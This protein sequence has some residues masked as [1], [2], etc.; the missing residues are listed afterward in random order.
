MLREKRKKKTTF[1]GKAGHKLDQK[2]LIFSKT[3]Q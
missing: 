2:A 3:P 1:P